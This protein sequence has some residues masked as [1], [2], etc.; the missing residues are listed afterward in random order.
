ML[1]NNKEIWTCKHKKNICE[2]KYNVWNKKIKSSD[3]VFQMKQ[4]WQL[5]LKRKTMLPGITNNMNEI[6]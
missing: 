4:L 6:Q 1:E 3:V 5:Q 2:T